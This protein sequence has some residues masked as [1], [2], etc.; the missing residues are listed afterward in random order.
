[1]V[2]W[3]QVIFSDETYVDVDSSIRTQFVRRGSGKGT[4]P[5][6]RS[7]ADSI[8]S[9]FCSGDASVVLVALDRSCQSMEPWQRQIT[10]THCKTT[11]YLTFTSVFPQ[12]IT[13]SCMIMRH[14]T[15][16]MAPNIFSKATFTRSWIGPRI[17]QTSTPSK[18]CG[19]LWNAEFM[20]HRSTPRRKSFRRWLVCG[21]TAHWKTPV[22][23]LLYQC[24]VESL[25]VLRQRVA[26]LVF[27]L[28]CS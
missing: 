4:P 12:G 17:H 28:S 25:N 22:A 16:P 26:T 2:L 14:A 10:W 27:D 8:V 6:I 20:L 3:V 23:P 5:N 9:E 24:P 11:F 21:Q 7:V 18:I 13:F 1:L 15:S 19:P